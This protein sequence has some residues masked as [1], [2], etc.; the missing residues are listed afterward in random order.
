MAELTTAP[1]PPVTPE[2]ELH[3]F[4]LRSLKGVCGAY[5]RYLY[6][7]YGYKLTTWQYHA[8]SARALLQEQERR[9]ANRASG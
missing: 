7:S 2:L 9:E 5:E 1:R 4:L 8:E 6:R 3:D